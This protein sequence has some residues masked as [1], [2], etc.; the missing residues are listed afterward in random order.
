MNR[1][2]LPERLVLKEYAFLEIVIGAVEV[3]HQECF[4]L[5]LGYKTEHALIVEDA[6]VVQSARRTPFHVEPVAKRIKRIENLVKS[7]GIEM[8]I[9]GDFHSHTQIGA[10]PARPTPSGEDIAD[11]EPG[12]AYLIIAINR[13]KGSPVIWTYSEKTKILKGSI[14]NLL[15]EISAYYCFREN[16]YKKLEIKC[17][18]VTPL[19]SYGHKEK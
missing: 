11:M 14:E 6:Q 12:N 7:I 10:D 13:L 5:I 9:I 8:G 2:Q 16:Q 15:F 17:P 19:E 1:P 3:F 18:F 4:G